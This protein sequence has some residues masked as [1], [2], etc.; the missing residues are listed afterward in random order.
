M[1]LIRAMH[2][3]TSLCAPYTTYK[4]HEF[5]LVSSTF[6]GTARRWV[7]VAYATVSV[8]PQW[9]AMRRAVTLVTTQ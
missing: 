8:M 2:L 9:L 5:S 4:L 3:N 1:S 7:V 6:H